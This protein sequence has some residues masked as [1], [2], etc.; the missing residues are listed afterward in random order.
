[1][2]F[3]YFPSALPAQERPHYDL[4]TQ[5]YQKLASFIGLCLLSPLFIIIG[6]AVKMTSKGPIFY[7]GQRVGRRR[8][9]FL[10]YKFRT[11]KVGSEAKIGQRLVRQD[12]D[13]YTSIGRFLRK[14]RLDEL[15]QLLNVLKGE[16][17]LVGPRPLRPIFLEDL[18]STTS[19]YEKR[20]WV[21]PGITGLA[22]VRGGYYTSPRHKLF[23]D[24]LYIQRRSFGFDLKLIA[25]TFLRVMTR[26]ISISF[27]L[28]WILMA[29]FALPEDLLSELYLKTHVVHVNLIYLILPSLLL[30]KIIVKGVERERLYI[31]KTP[32]DP[33][34][35]AASS[36]SLIGIFFSHYPHAA[37]RGTL[38]YLCNAFLPFYLCINS[39]QVRQSPRALLT[40]ISWVAGGM[41]LIAS[42]QVLWTGLT[43]G[44]W[45]RVGGGWNEPLWIS[46]VCLLSLPLT[47]TLWR[48]RERHAQVIPMMIA[49]SVSV[50]LIGAGSRGALVCCLCSIGLWAPRRVQ[51][52]FVIGLTLISLGYWGAG[53]Q[54]FTLESSWKAGVYHLNH[55]ETLYKTLEP[56]RLLIGVGAR[57][58]PFHLTQSQLRHSPKIIKNPSFRNTLSTVFVEQGLFGVLFFL[59]ILVKSLG[60]II[61]E[62]RRTSDPLLLSIGGGVISASLLGLICD[63][64]IPFPLTLFFWSLLGIGVGVALEKKKGP[65]RAYKVIHS[66]APL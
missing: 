56:K 43:E 65:K 15:P 37:F 60:L 26:I 8:S 35:L 5:V 10:I 53:D 40:K 48:Q 55:Q 62:G 18:L 39:I 20:F 6:I 46:T 24:I 31:L 51:R 30:L 66:H 7:R 14:Y 28:L 3:F 45:L 41:C 1:M 4:F 63:L 34:I 54:R 12:E 9:I 47:W 64:W 49:L 32:A 13:H 57:S 61:S 21:S 59:M 19:G 50:T 33:W 52:I 42:S 11:M 44:R 16:M 22:Q 38:W 58:A 23:Y 29:T 2:T 36:L 17:A 27:A 25:L